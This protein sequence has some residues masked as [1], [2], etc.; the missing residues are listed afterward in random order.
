MDDIRYEDVC[1]SSR[2]RFARNIAEIP[3]PN[4][5]KEDNNKVISKVRE[6]LGN[7]YLECDF[8]SFNDAEKQSYVEKHIVSREFAESK[9]PHA[10]F[11]DKD[12]DVRI[13]VCEE[14][15]IRIQSITRGLS[16]TEAYNSACRADEILSE[17]LNIAYDDNLGY[18]TKCPT[19]LGSAMRASVM[20]FLPGLSLTKRIR[21]IL[22]QLSKLGVAVRGIYGEGSEALGYIYQISNRETMGL[23]ESDILEKIDEI[24]KQI[25]QLERKA[26]ADLS[27]S[28]GDDLIDRVMRSLGTAKYAHL[29]SLTEF[30]NAYADIRMGISLGIIRDIDYVTVDK[31]FSDVMP[32]AI[33]AKSACERTESALSKERAKR[34]KEYL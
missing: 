28:L 25:I 8:D 15:H 27:D 7:K 22:S 4:A 3:F 31:L 23:T 2:I 16:L 12:G 10:L 21:S 19:N 5:S 30:M 1:I 9:L 20:L 17:G 29:L 33:I 24:S 32:G 18:L 34:I 6:A 14:D 26:R 11:S 13:M